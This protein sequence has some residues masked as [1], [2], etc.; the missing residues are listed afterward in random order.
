MDQQHLH[1]RFTLPVKEYACTTRAI[2]F[3]AHV[4]WRSGLVVV[5]PRFYLD[6]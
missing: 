4:L 5:R 6:L 1:A 2:V 3:S